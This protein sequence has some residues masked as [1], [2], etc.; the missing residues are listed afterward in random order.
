MEMRLIL[1]RLA[2]RIQH[3]P[4]TGSSANEI[5]TCLDPCTV[6]LTSLS[7]SAMSDS[8]TSSFFEHLSII[9][10][11]ARPLALM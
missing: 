9:E 6:S 10:A 4:E 3:V 7:A 5:P 1:G 11:A 2:N 8:P